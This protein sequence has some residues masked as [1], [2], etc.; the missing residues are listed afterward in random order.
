MTKIH[1]YAVSSFSDHLNATNPHVQFTSE[2]EK[3]G[4]IPFL[5]ICLHVTED[6]S[7]KVIVYRKPTHT[8]PYLTF[9]FNHHL[10]HKRSVVD[11]LLLRAQTLVCEEVDKVK[12]I[13][14]VKQASKANNYPDWMLT[15]P[16]TG[17]GLRESEETVNE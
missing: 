1:E 10:Q 9:H 12:E 15:V 8:D 3:N 14:N 2:E 5:D 6:G 4:G 11:A 17:S 13:Q 7:T 16:N